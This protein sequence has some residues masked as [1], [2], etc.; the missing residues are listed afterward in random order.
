M[1]HFE[2]DNSKSQS[3]LIKHGIDFVEAQRLWSDHNL[4]EIP[5]KVQDE[6]R[7]LVIAKIDDKHWSGVI[8]YRNQNIRII[9]V[10]RSRIQEVEFYESSG[11]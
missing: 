6:P 9:S 3:N 10:R 8:T 7:F 11:I 2:Y 4:I 1:I 5:A